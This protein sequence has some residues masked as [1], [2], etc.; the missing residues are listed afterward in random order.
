MNDLSTAPSEPTA[1]VARPTWDQLGLSAESLELIRKAGFEYPTPV[2][3]ESIP[4]AISK[5]DLV[6]SAAI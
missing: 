4:V 1:P 5:R 3:A 6:A 2:Q